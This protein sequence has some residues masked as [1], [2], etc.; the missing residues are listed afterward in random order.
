M[1]NKKG[2]DQV[3]VPLHENDIMETD[4]RTMKQ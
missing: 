1:I 4:Q 2:I 3:I